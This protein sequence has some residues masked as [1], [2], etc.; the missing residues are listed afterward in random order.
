MPETDEVVSRLGF[1]SGFQEQD[2]GSGTMVQGGH[3]VA[4]LIRVDSEGGRARSG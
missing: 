4:H 3:R 1:E 2:L